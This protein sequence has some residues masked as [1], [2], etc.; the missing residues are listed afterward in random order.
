MVQ[1]NRGRSDLLSTDALNASAAIVRITALSGIPALITRLGGEPASLLHQFQIDM[2]T[3][4]NRHA[5]I[6]YRT[7]A[8]ILEHAAQALSCPDFGLRLATLQGVKV[9]GPLNYVMGNSQTVLDAFR[10]S[11]DHL[12]VYST[13]AFMYLEKRGEVGTSF[14][15]IELPLARV[16]DHAQAVE[17]A[18]LLSQNA[19]LSISGGLVRAREIWFTHSAISPLVTYGEYFGAAIRFEQPVNGLL[20]DDADLMTPIPNADPQLYELATDFIAQRFP[21]SESVFGPRIRDIVERRLLAGDCTCASV[22]TT[23]G[24][25][26]RTLQRRLREEGESF[27]TIKDDVRRKIALRYLK[28]SSMPLSQLAKLLG[29]SETSA[30]SRSCYRWFAASPRQLREQESVER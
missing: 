9:L 8:R 11:Q 25:H 19:A 14:L 13:A 28:Q 2:A 24:M 4:A 18:L 12:Q 30:L 10:Y 23:L 21:A 27:E 15:R 3:L 6:P 26:P 20:F 17:R 29:Y 22:A 5:V 16:V 7:L 1:E